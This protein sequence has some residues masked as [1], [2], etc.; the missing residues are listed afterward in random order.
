MFGIALYVADK[1]DGKNKSSWT[2]HIL[3]NSIVFFIEFMKN[4]D[5]SVKKKT[6]CLFYIVMG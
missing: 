5:G 6:F 4:R 2:P 1:I 3:V